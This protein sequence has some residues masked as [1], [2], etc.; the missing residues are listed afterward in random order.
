LFFEISSQPKNSGKIIPR[1]FITRLRKDNELFAMGAQQDAHEYLNFLTNHLSELL[2]K[3]KSDNFITELFQGTFSNETR[4]ISCDNVTS[5]Q[6]NFLDLSIDVIGNSSINYCLRNFS[7]METIKG[8]DKFYCDHCNSLQEAQKCL[9]IKTLPKILI[10]HLKRF[11]F[12]EK[13]NAYKKL[14]DR[15]TFPF[16]LKFSQQQEVPYQLFGVV[17]HIGSGPSFG[18]YKSLVKSQGAW[19]SFDDEIVKIVSGN[20]I[21]SIYGFPNPDNGGTSETGYL[22]FYQME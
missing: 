3:E 12:S 21:Q 7:S 11:K 18:H 14:Q 22:L 17:N 2:I 9:K 15:V 16:E 8:E 1:G 5:R 6:E 19:I 13:L 20:Q 4:C 10:L